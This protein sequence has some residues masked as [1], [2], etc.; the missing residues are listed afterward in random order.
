M[1]TPEPRKIY[2]QTDYFTCQQNMALMATAAVGIT[3]FVLGLLA[4]Q[5][6]VWNI[7]G[8]DFIPWQASYALLTVGAGLV[9]GDIIALAVI[10]Y[11]HCD[12]V[13][14]QKIVQEK[15]QWYHSDGTPSKSYHLSPLTITKTK[16]D[17]SQEIKM[18][19]DKYE[20]SAAIF[21]L[22]DELYTRCYQLAVKVN[23]KIIFYHICDAAVKK[24]IEDD[25]SMIND[26]ELWNK[27]FDNLTP[28]QW[29]EHVHGSSSGFNRASS[30]LTV[31]CYERFLNCILRIDQDGN[32]EIYFFDLEK[33]PFA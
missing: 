1:N 33:P 23:A 20:M 24:E 2:Y 3:A 21:A 4:L 30:C 17:G 5:Q 8:L 25:V 32:R 19:K 16:E 29:Q 13:A 27:Q 15:N 9:V 18:Y 10:T 11:K 26:F 22:D 7:K 6:S 28:G 12:I 14:Q 31:L